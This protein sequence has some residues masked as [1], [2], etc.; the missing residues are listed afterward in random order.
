MLMQRHALLIKDKTSVMTAL[1]IL[2]KNS[3]EREGTMYHTQGM[4]VASRL[5]PEIIHLFKIGDQDIQVIQTPGDEADF[6][7]DNASWVLVNI[8][9]GNLEQAQTIITAGAIPL[10]VQKLKARKTWQGHQETELNIVWC[11]MNLATD[12]DEFGKILI[13]NGVLDL[14]V[15]NTRNLL[16]NE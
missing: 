7:K 13:A 2:R 10:M 16:S 5:T 6:I 9:A 14:L 1:K 12:R 15:P 4:Q 8:S 11:F 3:S